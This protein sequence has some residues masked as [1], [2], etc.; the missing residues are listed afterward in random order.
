MAVEITIALPDHLANRATELGAATQRTVSA[1]LADTLELMLP[2]LD[3]A[4]TDVAPAIEQL[5]DDELL[6]LADSCMDEAQ[7]HRLGMLQMRGKA[8]GLTEAE[9]Y[10]LLTLLHIYQLGQVRKSAALAEAVRRKLRPPLM[11]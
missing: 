1:V 5:S 10:E 3:R 4:L 11:P 6:G 2:T 7:N 9:R 8:E